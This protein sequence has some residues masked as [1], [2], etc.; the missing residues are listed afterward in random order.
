MKSFMICTP[1]QTSFEWWDRG[2]RDG[3]SMWYVWGRRE[4]CMGF[5]WENLKE[6]DHLEDLGIDERIMKWILM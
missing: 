3:W 5:C 2:G 1:H 4:M 6:R